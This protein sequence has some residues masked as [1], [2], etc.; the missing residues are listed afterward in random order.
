MAVKKLEVSEELEDGKVI[1]IDPIGEVAEFSP[2]SKV[3]KKEGKREHEDGQ[4]QGKKSGKDRF[5]PNGENQQ[6]KEDELPGVP[7]EEG[8]IERD[9]S[10]AKEKG[11]LAG[12]LFL[13]A[14]VD[15]LATALVQ[16]EKIQGV[17]DGSRIEQ[18]EGEPFFPPL[19]EEKD[20]WDR[21]VKHHLHLDGP[22]WRINNLH[23]VRHKHLR[24]GGLE[25]IQKDQIGEEVAQPVVGKVEICCQA[26][27]PGEEKGPHQYR[28]YI[29]RIDAPD[30]FVQVGEG[31]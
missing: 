17:G 14:Q 26:G 9:S 15:L 30:P 12:Q 24:Q 23:I 28:R 22:E 25:E 8:I 2:V 10:A 31:G 19:Q 27:E 16:V 6:G 20:E 5:H 18:K 13:Q 21:E 3:G 4:P 29:G 7:G 11:K 1:D